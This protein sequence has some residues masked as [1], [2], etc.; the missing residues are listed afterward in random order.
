M[1]IEIISAGDLKRIINNRMELRKYQIIDL[2][3]KKEYD[4]FHVYGA[5]NIEYDRFMNISNYNAFL[6]KNKIIILYCDRGGR[7]IYA[8]NRLAK[9]GYTVKSLSGG[10]NEYIKN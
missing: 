3:T 9:Y 10:I 5:V 6:N 4:D 8:V 7:S 2:R 1:N